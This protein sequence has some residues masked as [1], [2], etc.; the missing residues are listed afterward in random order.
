MSNTSIPSTASAPDAP[1]AP[2]DITGVG[3]SPG[4]VIGRIARMAPPVEAPDPAEKAAP[5]RSIDDEY[6]RITDAAAVVQAELTARAET[7]SGDARDVLEATAL[8]ASDPTLAKAAKKLLDDGRSAERAVWEAGTSIAEQFAALGGYMGERAQDVYDVRARLVAALRGVSAPG[9]PNPGHPYVLVAVD[10]APAD[11]ATLDPAQVIALVTSDGGPQSHTAILARALG[12]PAVVA[13]PQ[14]TTLVDG[15]EVYVDG[16]RGRV[17]PDPSDAERAD[18]DLAARQS[19]AL[20]PFDGTGRLSDGHEVALLANIGGVKDAAA[21]VDAN[22]QG[23]GLFRTEFLFLGRDT[24]P[25]VEEQVSDYRAVFAA[26]PGKKVVL[27]T[28]DAGADKPLAFLTNDDEPNPAL[29]I[30]GYRTSLEKRQVLVNQLRAIQTAREAENAD[31]WVM[32]P[33][34]ATADEAADFVGLCREAGL[35]TNG[36]MIEVPSA[37]LTAAHIFATADFVSLGTNDLTQYTMAADRQLGSLSALNDPWQPAVLQLV[38]HVG[39]AGRAAVSTGASA[40]SASGVDAGTG[41]ASA[42]ATT[43][44]PVGVCGEAAA[45]PALAVVLVGLGVT[46]LSMTSRAIQAVST[47][48]RSVTLD[49]AQTIAAAV[50]AAPTAADARRIAREHLPILE[51]LGL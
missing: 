42:S 44:K 16:T 24:E 15:V 11:T 10:L 4:R 49:E 23:V 31:V 19:E 7:V 3:V 40:G 2:S 14:A 38:Q 5:G 25:S 33:M 32:A 43:G 6:A 47:V 17:I 46:T 20:V 35:P 36:V 29:G 21:A 12:I 37:A 34:I 39:Q 8:M 18:A 41:A 22:A 51:T 30:R 26:F 45:D 1:A 48:L 13:A 27:R 50:V 28:L 9:L